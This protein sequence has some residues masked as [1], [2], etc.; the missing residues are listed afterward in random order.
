M[1]VHCQHRLG[2]QLTSCEFPFDL[3]SRAGETDI[4]AATAAPTDEPAFWNPSGLDVGDADV[5]GAAHAIRILWRLE[6]DVRLVVCWSAADVDDDPAVRERDHCRLA[7][8]NDLA[9]ENVAVVAGGAFDVR[10]DD[11]VRERDSVAQLGKACPGCAPLI[12]APRRRPVPV[13]ER[14]R[15]R[16]GGPGLR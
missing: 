11:E 3:V 4:W 8:E 10:G 15:G 6:N 16:R 5:Q 9:A 12:R 1:H 14:R 13:A 7:G 2:L